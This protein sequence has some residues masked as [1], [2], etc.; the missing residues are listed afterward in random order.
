[1]HAAPN[2]GGPARIE[3]VPPAGLAV[4]RY[5]SISLWSPAQR[6]WNEPAASTRL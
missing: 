6:V 4:R 5:A 3:R 2:G 1:M